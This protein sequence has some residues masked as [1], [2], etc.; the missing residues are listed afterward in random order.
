MIVQYLSIRQKMKKNAV[1]V[2]IRKSVIEGGSV[3]LRLILI[4]NKK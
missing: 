3:R 4:D 1:I 2:R